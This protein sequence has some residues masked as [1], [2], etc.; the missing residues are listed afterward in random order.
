MIYRHFKKYTTL[1]DE[2]FLA[3]IVLMQEEIWYDNH[4]YSSEWN[5]LSRLSVTF[6]FAFACVFL[7]EA[8]VTEFSKSFL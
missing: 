7:S 8:R 6:Y 1:R 4:E 3:R 2:I 5:S